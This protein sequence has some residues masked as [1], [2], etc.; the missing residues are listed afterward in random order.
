MKQAPDQSP[1]KLA[2]IESAIPPPSHQEDVIS[3]IRE[4]LFGQMMAEYEQRFTRLEENIAMGIER[5]QASMESRINE[6]LTRL[7]QERQ[8]RETEHK[9][10]ADTL[11]ENANLIQQAQDTLT[12]SLASEILG[13]RDELHEYNQGIEQRIARDQSKLSSY[14]RELADKL[15]NGI[16]S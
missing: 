15:E 13:V 5:L 16:E 12:Q 6:T 10:L 8:L 14:L 9:A 4:I 1:A 3:E 7:Q 11:K 2:H